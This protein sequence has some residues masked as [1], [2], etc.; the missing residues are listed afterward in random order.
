VWN[1]DASR[2]EMHLVSQRRQRV[3]IPASGLS[4]NFAEGETI[5][6]ESSYKYDTD[7]FAALLTS[8]SFL[9]QHQWIDS[10]GRFT[11]VLAKAN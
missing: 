7:S 10:L 8:S 1:G 3:D 2:I 4:L 5:W 11:L 9:P 6:T